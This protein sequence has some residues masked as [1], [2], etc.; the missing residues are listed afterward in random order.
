MKLIGSMTEQRFREEL[1]NTRQA[2]L[3]GDSDLLKVLLRH[4]PEL[5]SAFLLDWTPE[6][7]E[8]IYS[9]MVEDQYIAAVEIT[10]D[11]NEVRFEVMPVVEYQRTLKNRVAKIKLAVA[12]DIYSKSPGCPVQPSN[13]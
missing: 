3:S 12:L 5:R 8:D 11:G 1:V 4:F 2:L 6:Q 10:R 9:V 7:C 13:A